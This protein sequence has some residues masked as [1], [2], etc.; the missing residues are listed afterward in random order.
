MG[1]VISITDAQ[2]NE[3]VQYEYDAWG[4]ITSV[5][6]TNS[7]ESY[8]KELA[9]INPLRYRGYYLDSETG[10]YYLQSRYYSPDICRFINADSYLLT[11]LTKNQFTGI[12][13][14]AYCC[15][16]PINRIDLCGTLSGKEKRKLKSDANS[17]YNNS[18]EIKNILNKS[19]YKNFNYS[20]SSYSISYERKYKIA[21][22][23]NVYIS[24][25]N[26][27]LQL[28]ISYVYGKVSDIKD[29]AQ[30]YENRQRNNLDR[31]TEFLKVLAGFGFALLPLI[32]FIATLILS[33]DY[34]SNNQAAFLKSKI[35]GKSGNS[36][37]GF[38]Y[39]C[40]EY[41]F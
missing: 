33:I 18:S 8:D 35:K 3:L 7:Y 4:K 19:R 5:G 12:N 11:C 2:G 25:S 10:Y 9:N 28:G 14:F 16:D 30:S 23:S 38:V 13:I 37:I 27:N 24:K 22:I 39:S 29:I 34:S 21:I 32:L 17:S 40:N 1:D 36:Y 31:Q 6:S 20:P 41:N 26:K 15:N